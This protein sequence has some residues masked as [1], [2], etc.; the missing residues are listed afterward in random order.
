MARDCGY[1]ASVLMRHLCDHD[2]HGYTQGNGRWGDGEGTCEVEVNGETFQLAQGDRDCSSAVISCWQEAL[3]GTAYEGCLDNATYTGNMRDVFA[4]SG[5]FEV[6][7]TGSSTAC[8]GDVYLN[9]ADHTA[10]CVDDGSGDLGYDALGEFSI[11]ENG[12]IYGEVG[13]QTGSESS[14]HGYYDFPW[15]CTLHYNGNANGGEVSQ[16]SQPSNSQPQSSGD[17]VRYCLHTLN[18][19]WLPWVEDCNEWDDDGYAGNPGNSH[20]MLMVKG[21][22]YRV[23]TVDNG[24]LDWVNQAN[25]SDDQYGMA[26]IW[27]SAIDGIQIQGNFTYRTQTACRDGWLPWVTGCDDTDDG[28]AG[29]YGEPVDRLQIHK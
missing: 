19:D 28:Y 5:L 6:W 10:M 13:D 2:W 16:N 9:D 23:H 26:G 12:T 15:N 20:D 29:I 8:I 11:S 21:A 14:V 22:T 7:D 18:G 25:P 27:G 17:S 3:R 24:W 1:V 4:G